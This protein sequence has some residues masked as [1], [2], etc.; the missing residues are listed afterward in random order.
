ML[1]V[2]RK[3]SFVLALAP[4]AVPLFVLCSVCS[5]QAEESY[6]A[7][8][9]P[10]FTLFIT[11]AP[12]GNGNQQ[13]V[14]T[15]EM[16]NSAISILNETYEEY[17]RI[18]RTEPTKKVVLRFLSPADF[19]R[20][21]GAPAWTSAMYFRDEISIP[22]SSERGLREDDLRRALRHEYV[23]SIVAELSNF[24]GPAWLDEGVAQLLEGRPNPLLG[25]ALRDWVKLNPAIP[26]EWLHN[27]F[28]TLD[29][30]IVPAAYAQSL[31]AVRKLVRTSGFPA[32]TAYLTALGRGINAEQAF[33]DAFGLKQEAFED[34]LTR[35]MRRWAQSGQTHP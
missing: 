22:V 27:G 11:H 13:Q 35:E 20:R 32:V 3:K 19:R 12:E 33:A 16:A 25:P 18:F 7:F 34:Q 26:L 17:T 30:A 21:T 9:T 10:R 31:F 24:R 15:S 5:A 1:L 23:H 6:T 4:L 2:R 8:N 29:P 14:H 28:T